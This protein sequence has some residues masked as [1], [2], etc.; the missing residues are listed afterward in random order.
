M[1]PLFDVYKYFR[2]FLGKY[3]EILEHNWHPLTIDMFQMYHEKLFKWP[4]SGSP[5]LE[6][7]YMLIYPIH[8]TLCSNVTYLSR[9]WRFCI[10]CVY[11]R[12]QSQFFGCRAQ[13]LHLSLINVPTSLHRL[14]WLGCS[15]YFVSAQDTCVYW[16]DMMPCC[17]VAARR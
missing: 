7:K 17:D 3:L 9:A 5:S 10:V 15:R 2:W 11:P 12:N 13:I 4:L 6:C 14:R 16:Y 8:L 1:K